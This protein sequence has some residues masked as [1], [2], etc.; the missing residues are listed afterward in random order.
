[1]TTGTAIPVRNA[2]YLLLYAWDMVALGERW[3]ADA[4]S[5]PS[6]LS[7]LSTVLADATE[8]LLTRNLSRHHQRVRREVDG[9]RGR[10][11]WGRTLGRAQH[12]RGITTCEVSVLDVDTRRNRILKA[13][14]QRL[15][16]DRRLDATEGAD[17]NAL[18]ARLRGLVRRMDGVRTV[19]LTG[20]DF[21]RLQL[22]RNDRDYALPLSICELLF[23]AR[24]PTEDA[25]DHLVRSLLRDEITFHRLYERFVRGF[26]R[27]HL[28]GWR[29]HAEGLTWPDEVDS[30]LVPG[31]KT[32]VSLDERSAPF[33]RIVLDTKFYAAPLAERFGSARFHSANLYQM[34]AYLRTQEDRGERW[35]QARGVLL[36]PTVD[37]EIDARMVV[38]GYEI[39]V[40]TVD[41]GRP[42]REVE[43][44]LMGIVA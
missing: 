1:M 21:G 35:R 10:V 8:R 23:H 26:Y 27:R 33:R 19:S 5:S 36:Y 3:R 24:L 37:D 13:T 30:G 42:W 9:V 18:R 6:L 39:R 40:V 14:L 12:L 38:Q 44:R 15:A 16:G 7:L 43:D 28:R 25:G 22:G 31:M 17:V 2:W 11:D 32:D 34:Y 4:E 29:V 20:S 41:L